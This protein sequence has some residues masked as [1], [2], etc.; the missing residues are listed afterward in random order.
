[1]FGFRDVDGATRRVHEF[2]GFML[3]MGIAL[4]AGA[5]F[6]YT[7]SQWQYIC[8]AI[9]IIVTII[10]IMRLCH[11]WHAWRERMRRGRVERLMFQ[12]RQSRGD[13]AEQVVDHFD[14]VQR[15]PHTGEVGQ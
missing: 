12:R 3:V 5:L 6:A 10:G 11:G 4:F 14:R 2:A 8:F 13:V 9:V 7:K 1:M 15:V